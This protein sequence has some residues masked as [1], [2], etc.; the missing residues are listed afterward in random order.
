MRG[1]ADH[2]A[3]RV[4]GQLLVGPVE[5][6]E[7]PAL[8]VLARAR[9]MTDDDR[10]RDVLDDGVK[11]DLGAAQLRLGQFCFCDVVD[12]GQPRVMSVIGEGARVDCDVDL[13]SVGLDMLA[14]VLDELIVGQAM[15]EGLETLTIVGR[16]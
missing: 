2:A 1:F 15:D 8:R 10:E 5:Q 16:P 3:A 13:C 14:D 12:D 11:E 9:D 6:Q 4:A 7:A